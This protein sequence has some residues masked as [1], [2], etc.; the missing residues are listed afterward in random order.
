VPDEK[1]AEFIE[2]MFGTEFLELLMAAPDVDMNFVLLK[3][4]PDIFGKWGYGIKTGELDEIKN[5]LTPGL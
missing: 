5:M 4:V 1:I 2:R 3:L